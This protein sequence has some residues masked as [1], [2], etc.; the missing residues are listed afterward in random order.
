MWRLG[1]TRMR[2]TAWPNGPMVASRLQRSTAESRGRDLFMDG[3]Y[4]SAGSAEQLRDDFSPPPE[5]IEEMRLNAN[6]AC[7][8][9]A[10]FSLHGVSVVDCVWNKRGCFFQVEPF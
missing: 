7:D 5:M 6:A 1:L 4:N 3:V 10:G 8:F 9:F 2:V